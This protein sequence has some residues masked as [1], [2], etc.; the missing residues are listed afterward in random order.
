MYFP[1]AGEVTKI[2]TAGIISPIERKYKGKLTKFY[3]RK[4]RIILLASVLTAAEANK[5]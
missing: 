1:L 2:N 5:E 3:E 4:I